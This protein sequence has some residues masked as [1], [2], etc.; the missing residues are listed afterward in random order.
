M[1]VIVDRG[2]GLL[3]L[4]G[5]AVAAVWASGDRFHE[6]KLPVTLCFAGA[7]VGLFLVLHPIPRR[8]LH[9]ERVLA[10][11]PQAERLQALDRALR[12]YGE[13]KV[14]MLFAVGLS[15]ANHAS[16]AAGVWALGIA[17][18]EDKLMPLEYVGVVAI[19][20]VVSS[21]PLSPGGWGLG[22][23]TF[24][25]L[26]HVL[27]ASSTLGVAVSITYRLLIT[28]MNMSGGIFLLLPGGK[29][30]RVEGEALAPDA[31]ES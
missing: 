1:S 8:I 20:N 29:D 2:L 13:H 12:L 4:V 17:F 23:G 30:L 31:V 5:L 6:V 7:I 19:A 21:L 9:V 10:R 18:G 16:L 15:V 26:F 14:E 3:V 25:Y 22:E 11:L 27:G 28:A 24:G